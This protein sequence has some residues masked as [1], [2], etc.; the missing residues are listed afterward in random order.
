M[1]GTR[2]HAMPFGADLQPDGQAR[3]RL[4]AP[5]AG[6]V[7]LCIEP[8]GR[9]RRVRMNA[10]SG[11]WFEATAE[12]AAGTAY[13]FRIDGGLPVPDPASRFQPRGMSGPSQV[14]DP[15][16]YR[17]RNA[18]WAG[19]PW[20]ETVLYELHV[21]T[22][23]R[24]G[25]F[26]AAAE[27]LP[28]LADLGVT[29]VEVMPV[30]S[31]A[32]ERNWGYDGV[33]PFAPQSTYGTPAQ[34]KSFIDD[35]HA[36][37][38]VVLLDVV[39][40]H[41]GPEGNYLHAYA[42]DFFTDRHRTP[43]GQAIN[44][45]GPNSRTVRDFFI[46]NALYWLEEFQLDGL[47]FDAVH[48]ILDDSSPDILEEVAARVAHGPGRSRTIHLILENDRNESH[49][50]GAAEKAG[51]FTAQWND[52][53]HHACH[54]LLTGEQDGYYIDYADRPVSHLARCLG[55]GFAYQ[56]ERSRYRD[57]SR[58][59]EPSTALPLTAFI[60][61]L[62]NHD[63]VGNRAH[64]ERLT[65]LI[66]A[67]PL[68][69]AVSV[70]LLSPSVPA[71]FMGEEFGC[72]QPFLYFADFEGD[73][74]EAVRAGRRAEFAS[75]D[76]FG[77]ARA[78]P[79]IPDPMAPET[80][81][82]SVLRWDTLD[83]PEHQAWLGYYA[84]LLGLRQRHVVPRLP[85]AAVVASKLLGDSGL[86]IAW[87]MRDGAELS[88]CANLGRAPAPAPAGTRGRLLHAEPPLAGPALSA[89]ELPPWS[90]LWHLAP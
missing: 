35:A 73:L 53:F 62:Q 58:R 49:Y 63:Q 44:F 89:R 29:A 52:D 46:H 37:G 34:M 4:W 70:L 48:A 7:E 36:H 79:A 9:E 3:F 47:R 71:L 64:G 2:R 5:D 75:F 12:A 26:E 78:G 15:A 41:F 50:L 27:R 51:R 16:A 10:V 13:R 87:R 39:Y 55:E 82:R 33:L 86:R 17:W 65:M 45:D 38:L 80:F 21:G 31:F 72:R 54:T 56:G 11:G 18:H 57:G 32:G 88:V 85:A 74:K 84:T 43:W 67:P 59:G 28:Y 1:G 30:A 40:N 23:T 83:E 42:G 8:P 6:R 19:R 68:R 77:P 76:R 61:F 66:D 24:R 22:F 69:A 90:V 60:A 25:T 14:V 81:Q 20:H